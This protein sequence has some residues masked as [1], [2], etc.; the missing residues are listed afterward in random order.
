MNG[1]AG[2]SPLESLKPEGSTLKGCVQSLKREY[3]GPV[4]GMAV[5]IGQ[6]RQLVLRYRRWC[7]IANVSPNSLFAA[8]KGI[9]GPNITVTLMARSLFIR[10][11]ELFSSPIYYLLLVPG[12]SSAFA[13][14][15]LPFLTDLEL[16]LSGFGFEL[17]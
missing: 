17:A 7:S 8:E 5:F 10:R 16:G 12:S 1:Y 6:I 11:A 3:A 2:R 13:S 15:L 14:Y 9:T 4:V